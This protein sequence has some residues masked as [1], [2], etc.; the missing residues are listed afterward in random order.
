MIRREQTLEIL[1]YMLP[2]LCA[3]GR[4]SRIIQHSI[5]SREDKQATNIFGAA[6]SDADVSIQNLVEVVLLAQ[7]PDIRFYGEEHEASFN[8]KYFSSTNFGSDDELLAILDPIDGTRLYLDQRNDYQI[9]F[10]LMTPRGFEGAI[11]LSPAKSEYFYALRGQ[12]AFIGQI[13]DSF[14][15]CKKIS[16]GKT[17]GKLFLCCQPG[18]DG[19]IFEDSFKVVDFMHDY[20]AHG[21]GFTMN[22]LLLGQFDAIVVAPAQFLDCALLC[23][24]AQE[25]GA[26]ITDHSGA[27]LPLASSV[28]NMKYPNILVARNVEIQG[29]VL[30]MI[31]KS[32]TTR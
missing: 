19:K 1:E 7:Y 3:A 11:A 5:F 4:Y 12:G 16:L 15:K 6:L 30:G 10:G 22:E 24:I 18:L 13:S 17:T 9:L 32:N 20:S 31:S 21:S 26:L 25:A 23:F 8:T 29:K 2:Y 14:S 27:D 28:P